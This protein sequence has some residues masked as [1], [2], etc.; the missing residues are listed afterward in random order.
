ML[1]VAVVA[2]GPRQLPSMLRTAGQWTAKL[3]RLALNM[4][5]QSGIDTL[6]EQEGIAVDVRRLK[7]LLGKR[8][9]VDAL[10]IDTSEI[11]S[12]Y[13]IIETSAHSTSPD[14]RSYSNNQSNRNDGKHTTRSAHDGDLLALR[15]EYPE[16]G[17]DV[18]GAEPEVIDP[19]QTAL[20]D[21]VDNTSDNMSDSSDTHTENVVNDAT[22][23]TR[24]ER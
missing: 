16:E 14:A 1:L 8:N 6:L 19:Y 15:R 12:G 20:D 7:T 18:Y 9:W 5:V 21:A 4:R 11:P 2:I 23:H 22:G 3:R 17:V 24:N 10:G 13:D